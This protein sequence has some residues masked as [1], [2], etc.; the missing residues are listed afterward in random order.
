MTWWKR[1]LGRRELDA[2]LDQELR[3]HIER[4]VAADVAAGMSEVAARRRAATELGGVEQAKEACREVRGT[5]WLEEVAHD[6]R[7][8]S[9]VLA[10]SPGFTLVAVLSLALGIG[11]NTAIFS[12]MNSLLLRT[13][14][15]RAP[16]RLVLLDEGSWTN[17]IWEEIRDRHSQL[18]AGVA[19][20]G[21]AR[22]DLASGGQADLVEGQWVSGDFF[23]VLGVQPMLGRTLTAADDRRGGGADGPVVMISYRFWQQRFGGRA[24]IVG[25]SLTL[26]RVV[27]TI[28]G[29]TPPEFF[30]PMVGRSFDVAV[31]IGTE[32]LVRTDESWLDRPTTRWLEIIARLTPDQTVQDATR[33]LR[34]VQPQ[35]REA[36]LEERYLRG[37]LTMVP[38]AT[39]T[40][41][42]RDDYERPLVTLMVVVGLVLLIACANIANL[43]LARASA[44]RHELS[45]RRALGASRLR[46][47][48][49]L[50]VESM[51]LAGAGAV[52]GL[53]LAQWGSRLLLRQLS[54]FGN[55]VFL[56]LS[57]D[58]RVIG[59]TAAVGIG[60]ALLLGV[61]PAFR[62]GRA[63]PNDVLKQHSRTLAGHRRNALGQLL[64]VGQIALA[65]VLVVAAGLFIR[66][67]S[68]L[69]TLDLGLDRD[70]VL[71]VSV[72]AQRS[73]VERPQR[74]DL[75]HR[76]VDAVVAAPGVVHAAASVM[77]PISGNDWQSHFMVA[78]RPPLSE[79]E[80][81]AYI[82]AISPAWFAT[83]GI[84]LLAGRDFD[85]RDRA[86][87][88]AVAIV[89][90]R[91]A[92]RFFDGASPIGRAIQQIPDTQRP[93]TGP[94][95]IVG[96]V[97]DAA[98]RSVRET[99]PPTVYFPLAQVSR[100]PDSAG[101]S[102]SITA[103]WIDS[104]INIGVRS[105]VGSPVLLMK[106]VAAAVGK[107]DGNLS[108]SLQLVADQINASLLPER[109]V[110]MLA[111][112]FGA[113]ALL[114]AAIGLYGVMSY[115][116]S[117]RRAEIGIR[118]A[119][120]A[121]SAKVVRL[122]LGRAAVLISLGVVLG[123]AVSLWA[124]RFVEALLYGLEP[125]DPLTF[126]SAV[127]VLASV[128]ALAAWL[129]A[130]RAAR[131]DPARVLREG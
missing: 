109:L 22:F 16:E 131:I 3:D 100:E 122:V 120:G 19:A 2:R 74:V 26:N 64:L 5:R 98:Y 96:L 82:N 72:D 9:R 1:L 119:L 107:V 10:A 91:F 128:G 95:E 35:I 49:Q 59:F 126:V 27:F 123:A 11:A 92:R 130:R 36:T 110:A 48:R 118:M 68:T 25:S 111:G 63:E 90:E 73:L 101:R 20:W 37:A 52:L 34:A 13:L 43:L 46:L 108:L 129:P 45:M 83:Y 53:G 33:A 113:L 104:G 21:N 15:V 85:A 41:R 4:Q 125:H 112:F 87:A 60:T 94:I 8:G 7:Y 39:G 56:D 51:L 97:E 127:M 28:V 77:S 115:S 29:V 71:V 121:D 105:G 12:L 31:P 117:R 79:D 30:G 88:P 44:R 86:E 55:T 106:S 58:W 102:R 40:S 76:V 42:I 14:P 75:F 66:T 89:N 23:D 114:L 78:G 93:Q 57:L 103:P 65:L 18:F 32:P 17:P 50:L 62:A 47:M 84:T 67:L 38:A 24:E 70:P 124:S 80:S 69:N 99:I 116:I 54:S 81:S 61:V 6:V